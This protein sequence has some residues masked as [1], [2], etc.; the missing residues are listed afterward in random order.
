MILCS[1]KFAPWVLLE[2]QNWLALSGTQSEAKPKVAMLEWPEPFFYGGHWVPEMVEMAGG[3]DVLGQ[4]GVDSGRFSSNEL[5]QQDPDF[6]IS[7]A[8]GYDLTKN[9]EFAQMIA[10]NPE[11]SQ[12]K[13]V[14]NNNVWAMDA[15]SYCSRPTLR[16]VDGAEKLQ[17]IF[18][19]QAQS[20]EG[21]QRVTSV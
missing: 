15:N 13:A 8:C 12:L 9:L 1:I 19:N 6:I 11:F 16:I 10:Q 21:I 18:L 7:I 14:Q 3:L 17:A 5:I 20:I 2:K 4:P